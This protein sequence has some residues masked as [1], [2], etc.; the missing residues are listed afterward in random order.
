M[1]QQTILPA[2][3]NPLHLG[4]GEQRSKLGEG[5]RFRLDPED[6]GLQDQWFRAPDVMSEPISVP[7]TWQGQ[8]FGG[9]GKDQVW[10]FRLRA[11]TLR[12]TYT[13]TGWYANTFRRSGELSGSR[14]FLN[15]GA[16]HPSADVWLNGEPLGSHGEPF[17]P[18]AFEITDRVRPGDNDLVVRVHEADRLFGLAFSFQGNWSGLYRGVELSATGP[19]ALSHLACLPDPGAEQLRIRA[20]VSSRGSTT[21]TLRM[22]VR[23][24]GSGGQVASEEFHIGGV[25]AEHAVHVPAPALW[26]PDRPHLYRVDAVLMADGEVSD[27][28]SERVGFTTLSAEGKEFLINGEP[29]YMR[30]TGAFLP[31][32][33]T[34][35]PDT[36]RSRLRTRLANL[37]AYGY[38]YVRCQ[39]YV[40]APEEYDVA[41][42]LGL[43]IQS[44]MGLLGGWGG[45][46][47]QHIYAWPAPSPAF[48]AKLKQQWDHTVARD[49][50]HPS[51]NLYCM[52]NELGADTHY[53]RV[54]WESY[55]DTKA[56]KPSAMVIW[57]DGGYNPDLP[58]E[59]V[60]AEASVECDKPL[61]QHEFRW[62]SSLPDPELAKR[63]TGAL[64]PYAADLAQEA[65]ARHGV[66]HAY[67]QG[68]KNSQRLQFIE[69]KGKMEACRREHGHLAGICHFNA[70][71]AIPSPQGIIDEFYERK[72][73]TAAQ[74]QQTNGDTVIL[75]ALGFDDRVLVGGKHSWSVSVSDFSHPP[76]MKPEVRWQF[77]IE[78]RTV[79]EGV[80][81]PEHKPFTT[82]EAGE[83]VAEAPVVR[84]P[85]PATLR[86]EL[87]EKGRSVDNVWD[88]WVFPEHV[89]LPEGV[90]I[91]G[92][93]KHTWVAGV[94]ETA[95]A[96]GAAVLL[97]ETLDD[98]VLAFAENGGAVVLAAS[99]GLVRPFNPKLGLRDGRYFFTPPANYGPYEDG[100]NATIV[101]DH[102]MLGEMPHEG[103]A[104][105]QLYRTI[106]ESPPL[107]LEP[108]GLNDTDPVIRV[109]HSYPV[110]RSLGYLVERKLGSGALIVTALDFN[111][112]WPEARYLLAAI[113]RYALNPA[114]QTP[115][116]DETRRT[117]VDGTSLP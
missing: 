29:Y 115:L 85:T 65:A 4:P 71:D 108:L 17:V 50:N 38:N 8:G 75:L 89:P 41:D 81:A 30:G 43:L 18:F 66:A 47:E 93:A 19:A 9:D 5:W 117:L 67:G 14:V 84:K 33:E 100:H 16:V 60:N 86:A 109:L 70:M 3:V 69:A 13:G 49:V 44:E 62:W 113:C 78:G 101:A 6:V 21:C 57:T 79:S 102:A 37:R 36:D 114:P 53:P 76:F 73:A 35:A 46:N 39:S 90:G 83:V 31:Y 80:L 91:Y 40:P 98:E 94:A 64:R 105:L 97:S 111:Q 92:E 88:F 87:V 68:A 95:D 77:A 54:A 82:C 32:P 23:H 61:I 11:R 56:T 20:T 12:A 107:D 63:Y 34:A 27:A 72:Y 10:D 59:F 99:E 2:R 104:D 51:A 55:H 103:L 116:S 74:W 58:G 7:G 45:H 42:E 110:G 112:D 15:F 96:P 106:A 26:S 24:Y 1:Q 52:S 48:R 28:R 22:T 25:D